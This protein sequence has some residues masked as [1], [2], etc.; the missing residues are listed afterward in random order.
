MSDVNQDGKDDFIVTG[1]GAPNQVYSY[2]KNSDS[3]VNIID[4][5]TNM[6][7]SPASLEFSISFL[8]SSVSFFRFLFLLRVHSLDNN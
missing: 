6:E 5:V 2:D 8:S 7:V 3:Y 1:N 4:G